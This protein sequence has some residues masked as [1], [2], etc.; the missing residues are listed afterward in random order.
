MKV[1]FLQSEIANP[2]R[3]DGLIHREEQLARA[4]RKGLQACGDEF[5]AIAAPKEPCDLDTDFVAFVGMKKHEW[6]RWCTDNGQ[7]WMYFDKGY[8]HREFEGRENIILWR[9]SV[10]MPQPIEYIA[11]ARHN[12]ERWLNLQRE[13]APW[14]ES[15][16]HI[17]VAASSEKYHQFFGLPHPTEWVKQVIKELREYTQ[18]P[19]WYRPKPSWRG[20]TPVK[21]IERYCER[22]PLALL[23]PDAH[24]LITH[25]SYISVDALLNGVPSIVLG[26]AVTRPISSTS[27]AE[28]E[29]PRLASEEE[30]LQML[31]NLAWCQYRIEEWADGRA[32]R[33]VKRLFI[34]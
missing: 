23:F 30:R 15:G 17:I 34:Q 8:Y 22:E 25:G 7:R 32:W 4:L 1:T 3:R 2:I 12:P 18:R 11:R 5:E 27:L 21:G 26:P 33:N 24:A 13:C 29:D 9:V 16:R 19:I 31:A 10:D 28:I 20:K 6:A 14:R